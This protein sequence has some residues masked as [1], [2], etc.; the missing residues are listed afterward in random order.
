MEPYFKKPM[1]RW[2]AENKIS[3]FMLNKY[4]VLSVNESLGCPFSGTQIY[5]HKLT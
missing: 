5:N 4:T 3:F 2:Q 1:S